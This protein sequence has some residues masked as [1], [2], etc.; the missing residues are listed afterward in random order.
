LRIYV[1]RKNDTQEKTGRDTR[2][3]STSTAASR[4]R[5]GGNGGHRPSEL[6]HDDVPVEGME[7]EGVLSLVDLAGSEKKHRFHASLGPAKKG[8]GTNQRESDG[9]EGLRA[10]SS[11]W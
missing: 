11:Q 1:R 5:W 10:G 2:G 6:H 3:G 4:R 7:F 9:F 8:G